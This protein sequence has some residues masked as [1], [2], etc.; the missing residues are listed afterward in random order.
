M[1]KNH[2]AS[3]DP[4]RTS[5]AGVARRGDYVFDTSVPLVEARGL[6]EM[7]HYAK[8]ASNTAVALHGFRDNQTRLVAI[9]WWLPPTKVAAKSVSKEEWRFVLSLSRLVV[10]PDEPKNVCSMLIGASIRELRRQG[11]WRHLVTY[12]DH[13]Q[14]HTGAIYRATNWKH[15]GRTGPYPKWVDAEGRQR[16]RKATKSRTASQMEALGMRMVGR[17]HKEKFVMH[18]Y[19]DK[20]GSSRD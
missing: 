19:E 12:A 5:K 13:S 11:V 16:S 15:V 20:G 4:T 14:G 9:A 1:K 3:T 8:G 7:Y 17:F 6:V 10:H 18:L 2:R